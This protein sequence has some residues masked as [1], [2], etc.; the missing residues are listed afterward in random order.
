VRVTQAGGPRASI[1]PSFARQLLFVSCRAH[2]AARVAREEQSTNIGGHRERE[3]CARGH[4]IR[5]RG[6]PIYQSVFKRSGTGSRQEDA[7]NEESRARF[8]SSETEKA[9]GVQGNSAAT[10]STIDFQVPVFGDDHGSGRAAFV[11]HR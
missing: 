10:T 11:T 6:L 2:G 7:S 9:R 8:D 1:R 3:F 4:G 5:A